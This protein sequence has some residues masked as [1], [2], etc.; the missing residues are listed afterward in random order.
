[1]M[2]GEWI[3]FITIFWERIL[4]KYEFKWFQLHC[5]IAP[6]RLFC[7]YHQLYWINIVRFWTCRAWITSASTGNMWLTRL[8]KWIYIWG[9]FYSS[10]CANTRTCILASRILLTFPHVEMSCEINPSQIVFKIFYFAQCI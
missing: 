1:M 2:Y 4:C 5:S 8:V 3:S 9:N 6:H 7:K 10:L